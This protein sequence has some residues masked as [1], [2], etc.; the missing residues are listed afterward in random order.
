[1]GVQIDKGGVSMDVLPLRDVFA[2]HTT[3][4]TLIVALGLAVMVYRAIESLFFSEV[5]W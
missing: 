5:W 1:M 4:L 3:I 2:V